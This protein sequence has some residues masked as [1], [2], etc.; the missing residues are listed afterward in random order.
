MNGGSTSYAEVMFRITMFPI[1]FPFAYIELRQALL[2]RK[3]GEEGDKKTKQRDMLE[4]ALITFIAGFLAFSSFIG[5]QLVIEQHHCVPVFG[6]VNDAYKMALLLMTMPMSLITIAFAFIGVRLDR[7]SL[8][9]STPAFV[10]TTFLF[11]FV[12]TWM[13]AFP[14]AEFLAIRGAV[15]RGCRQPE[16]S[17]TDLTAAI[18]ICPSRSEFYLQRSWAYSDLDLEKERRADASKANLLLARAN[19]KDFDTAIDYY[20]GS[21]TL[22]PNSSI[23][24]AI[25]H[26]VLSLCSR[27]LKRRP[28]NALAYVWRAHSY[29]DLG[30]FNAAKADISSLVHI[31]PNSSSFETS[32][33]V[34]LKCQDYELAMQDAERALLLAPTDPYKYGLVGRACIA[35]GDYKKAIKYYSI[36][37]ENDHSNYGA[38]FSRAQ[39]YDAIGRPDL[40]RKDRRIGAEPERL[41]TRYSRW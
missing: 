29:A 2:H 24:D 5:V 40:A 14:R 34:L 20:E 22:A 41:A 27:E 39:A 18:S 12:P 31:H 1:L 28:M 37:I 33:R 30:M 4:L 9:S 3:L 23:K 36:A 15:Y 26:E 13:I 8:R 35:L 6:I 21:F 19:D 7:V 25:R 17:I 11:L 38:F 32:A 16:K 10:A